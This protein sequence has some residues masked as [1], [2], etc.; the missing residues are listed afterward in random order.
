MFTNTNIYL[1]IY[2]GEVENFPEQEINE[3]LHAKL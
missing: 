3:L 1:Q 2:T